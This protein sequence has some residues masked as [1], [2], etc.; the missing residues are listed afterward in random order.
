MRGLYRE[1]GK[2]VPEEALQRLSAAEGMVTGSSH[3]GSES[4]DINIDDGA[5]EGEYLGGTNMDN[6]HD[7]SS[8]QSGN[9]AAA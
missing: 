8:L 6:N 3:V 1:L 2:E 5:N 9:H 7:S 4:T